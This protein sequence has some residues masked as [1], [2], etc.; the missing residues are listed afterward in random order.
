MKKTIISLAL[1]VIGSL[2]SFAQQ[3]LLGGDIS[4]LTKYEQAG[5]TYRDAN[6][7]KMNAL[8]L[9]KKEG[10]NAMRLRLFVDPDQAPDEHKAEGVCQDI[11]YVR[12]LGKRIK[13]AGF[14]LMLDFHY[15]DT[16]A[17]PGKQ[18]TPAS[19]KGASA[20]ALADSVYEYTKRSLLAMKHAGAEPDLI[21]VGNEISFGMLWPTAKTTPTE[22]ANWQ[23]FIAMLKQG[24]KAC[25]EI[26]PKAKIIIHTEQAGKW[27][28][29]KAFYD[30]LA[31]VNLD[32]D[33]IGLSYYPMWHDRIPVLHNTLGNLARRYP[34]KQ[35]MIVEAA[36]YYSHKNDK[37]A[38]SAD[39]FSEFYPISVEGQTSFTRDLV[40]ELNKHPQV[41]GLFWWFPEENESGNTQIKS[42]LNRGLFDNSTGKALPSIDEMKKFLKKQ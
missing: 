9:F 36:A 11:N 5:T 27:D 28:N 31:T 29:T 18:F 41:T 20:E 3:R 24:C 34:A 1:A 15:S 33:I 25:R 26:C 16:W 10:W 13:K 17:D 37:W 23:K 42:W 8:K 6:G 12:Q 40:E 21:Q 7:K 32:Y 38:K 39:E 19:W 14:Q 35:I 4:M 22:D 30:R 2:G